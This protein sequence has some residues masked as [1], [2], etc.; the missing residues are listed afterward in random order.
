MAEAC[1]RAWR[2]FA[3]G[4]CF[5]CFGL[6]GIVLGLA[7]TLLAL[8]LRDERRRTVARY[9]IRH[10][11]RAF[12]GLMA[13]LGVLS[14]EIHGQNRLRG[15]GLLILANHPT[16][17]DVVFL[18]SF[19][20]RADCIV[21]SALARNPF[22]RGPVQAAGFV[23]NDSGADLIDDCIHSVKAG[24]NL[25]IF[26]EGTRT[27]ASGQLVL[28]RGAARVAIHGQVD[29]TP[30]RITCSPMTLGKGEKWYRVP[31]RRAHFRIEVGDPIE[32]APFV[33]AQAEPALAARQL[34]R[35]L[36]DYFSMELYSARA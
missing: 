13:G 33:S 7:F 25:I 31:P 4:L 8:L 23:F 15:G 19:V 28:Q 22:T 5:F 16:L 21:K 10:T 1:E 26:P 27:P 36:T 30:V 3:T 29:I 35:H 12:V 9:V 32:I 34:T 24:N 18:M 20:E 6:G 14:Y 17:I 11:F 2:I